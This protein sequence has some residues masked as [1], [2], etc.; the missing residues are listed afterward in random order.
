M[1]IRLQATAGA[2]AGTYE[3][4]AYL[5]QPNGLSSTTRQGGAIVLVETISGLYEG[6]L[7]G[8]PAGQYVIVL[9]DTSDGNSEPAPRFV[10]EFSGS[11]EISLSSLASGDNVTSSSNFI[12]VGTN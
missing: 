4:D 11:V 8:K 1:T 12:A 3:A 7:E 10:Y 5:V 2:A 6:T 9:R